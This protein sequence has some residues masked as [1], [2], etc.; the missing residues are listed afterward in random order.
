MKH[1]II[2]TNVIHLD[3]KLTS[4]NITALVSTS[5]R[6]SHRIYIP[7]V[8]IDEIVKQYK[9]EI[10]LYADD[11][12]RAVSKLQKRKV[13]E[14]IH[15]LDSDV[16]TKDYEDSLRNR[17]NELGIVILSYP[18]TCHKEMVSR[19]LS[20]RKPFLDGKKGY[21]DALIWETV[22]EYCKKFPVNEVIFLSENSN[23]FADKNKRSFHPDLIIDCENER[24]DLSRLSLATNVHEFVESKI[25]AKSKNLDYILESLISVD[26][27]GDVNF[28]KLIR[29]YIT[30]DKLDS[31]IN[32]DLYGEDMVYAP[33]VYE[34][35][36]IAGTDM[37]SLSYLTTKLISE[38]TILVTCQV[39]VEA[40][41]DVFIYKG[42]LALID[43]DMMPY[44]FD[45]DWNN[46]YCAA[47][48]TATFTLKINILCDK[49][50][51]E[52]Q[53]ID[54]DVVRVNYKTGYE[55]V[56]QL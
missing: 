26:C 15:K 52:V 33:G 21:R 17:I 29:D 28:D 54:H 51:N 40:D 18:T 2:D 50:L 27:C 9:E 19:E 34:N 45:R 14:E 49:D 41:M 7:D 10:K 47:S 32:A 46:H 42:D 20:K 11:Y 30:I 44:I 5:D 4:T 53:G 35:P 1:I 25:L 8:V 23:D 16:M 6:L 24:I 56:N 48:D 31:Y 22:K 3:Y 38:S 37:L 12:N 55:F 13:A 36:T 39:E 43:E